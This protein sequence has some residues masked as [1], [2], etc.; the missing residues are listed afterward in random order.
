MMTSLGTG[1][2]TG[3]LIFVALG[4]I[5]AFAILW[6]TKRGRREKGEGV[7]LEKAERAEPWWGVFVVVLLAVLLGLTIWRAPWFSEDDSPKDVQV[8]VTGIQFGFL[9][10]PTQVKAGQTVEFNVTSKDVN[11]AMGLFDPDGRLNPG[12]AL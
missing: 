3:Y 11:H 1:I 12:K 6:S 5:I 9:V 7:N 2:A 10:Q 8:K 4:L